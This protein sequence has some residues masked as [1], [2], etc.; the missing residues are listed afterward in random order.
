MAAPTP[1]SALVHSSTLVTAGLWVLL[2]VG[3]GGVLVS[4]LG[5]CTILLGGF[6]ALYEADLKKLVAFSTLSQLGLLIV[7]NGLHEL[8]V[9][10]GHL[11]RHAFFKSVLFVCVGY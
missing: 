3:V 5:L 9:M 4:S 6:C 11:I 2:K 8:D 10:F 1:V 7:G